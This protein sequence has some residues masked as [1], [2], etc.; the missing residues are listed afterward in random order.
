MNAA[1]Q[2]HNSGAH[3]VYFILKNTLTSFRGKHVKRVKRKKKE[4][5]R[6]DEGKLLSFKMDLVLFRT[7]LKQ[8]FRVQAGSPRGKIR[9]R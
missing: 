9:H 3:G 8:G 1:T 5:K 7:R 6:K 4:R 2:E